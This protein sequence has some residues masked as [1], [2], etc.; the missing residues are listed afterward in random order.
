MPGTPVPTLVIGLGGSGSWTV[1][2]LKQALMDTYDN[3]I[4][5]N[6]ALV[7]L[8]T[9]TK[10]TVR[11][12][13]IEYPR[14]PGEGIGGVQLE[15]GEYA[16]LGGDVYKF[17]QEVRDT[18]QYRHI[19]SWFNA[20]WKLDT[21]PRSQFNLDEGAGMW[22]QFGRMALFY[23]L[24]NPNTSKTKSRIEDSLKR[25]GDTVSGDGSVSVMIVGSMTGGTGAGLFLD[26]AHI[27]KQIAAVNGIKVVIRGF[28]YLPQ[29]FNRDLDAANLERARQRS[30]AAM[31]E[32]ERFLLHDDAK[33]G[34]P[35]HY[36][37]ETA[38]A[39]AR[40]YR[41]EV[42]SKLYDFVYLVDGDG[43]GRKMNNRRLAEAAAPMVADAILAFMDTYFGRYQNQYI[44]NIQAAVQNQQLLRGRQAYVGSLG[45]YSIVL[46]I[47]NIIEGWSYRL[48]LETMSAVVAPG[49]TAQQRG[50]ILDLSATAN[51]E[52]KDTTPQR[53][54][55][56]LLTRDAGIKD[57]TDP[58]GRREFRPYPLWRYVNDFAKELTYSRQN[59]KEKLMARNIEDWLRML[60][61]PRADADDF[62]ARILD[63][64]DAI[65]SETAQERVKT[66]KD[67]KANPGSDHRRVINEAEDF[68]F[69]Q[70]GRNE[71]GGRREGGE[72]GQALER[73][74]KAQVDRF[75]RGMAAYIANTLNGSTKDDAKASK[76]GKLGW[77]IKVFEEIK[78][79]FDQAQSLIANVR[80]DQTSFSNQEST[81]SESMEEMAQS[82]RE[83]AVGRAGPAHR[84]QVD[85][86][87]LVQ[88][89]VDYHRKALLQDYVRMAI[90]GIIDVIEQEIETQFNN[91]K[92]ALATHND[93][94]YNSLLR[95]RNR[96]DNERRTANQVRS[97][98]II[99]DQQWEDK[100]YDEYVRGAGKADVLMLTAWTWN[101]EVKEDDNGDATILMGVSLNSQDSAEKLTNDMRGNWTT[102]NQDVLLKYARRIFRNAVQNESI[103]EFLMNSSNINDPDDDRAEKRRGF[104]SNPTALGDFLKSVC[105][106]QLNID[107][108][109]GI[110]YTNVLLAK[111]DPN[112]SV[113]DTASKMRPNQFLQDA[114]DQL[115]QQEG[116]AAAG[117]GGNAAGANHQVLEC[118]DP[119]RLTIVSGAEVVPVSAVSAYRTN[120]SDYMK[121]PKDARAVQH[122][123]TPEQVAVDYEESLAR[124]PGQSRRVLSTSMI[125][126]LQDEERLELFFYYVAYKRI[127]RF[128]IEVDGSTKFF[129]GLEVRKKDIGAYSE[130]TEY[131]YL[132]EPEIDPYFLEAART[133]ILR[134]KD[135]R[136]Y[137][138]A[139]TYDN[140]LPSKRNL[141]QYMYDFR[142]LETQQRI[143]HNNLALD[144]R[145]L[146]E[147]YS[148][149]PYDTELRG[150]LEAFMPEIAE[151]EDAE[152]GEIY[153]DFDWDSFTPDEKRAFD[154][155]AEM[156]VQHDVL[157]EL[158]YDLQ[159][160]LPTRKANLE[161]AQQ[162]RSTNLGHEDVK[163]AE[164]E[165]DF[166][167]LAV[168]AL[169][170]QVQALRKKVR[171]QYRNRTGQRDLGG[172][173]E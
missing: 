159:N 140:D 124:L 35:M 132:S 117:A 46:P 50:T 14:R 80:S 78:R 45:A 133:F 171:T 150:W 168:L 156:V 173:N 100:R 112:I 126:V 39:T 98:W 89:Y 38:S 62:T 105:G 64:T 143:E 75:R 31:R 26:V 49:E 58:T 28:L 23:D 131:I 85:F 51:V 76:Q 135:I 40:I 111:I 68:I 13:A 122:I 5:S 155:I 34:Y 137:R 169:D 103:V 74:A 22:R 94:L 123:F 84:A 30:Y 92:Q 127:R 72:Y 104:V 147:G 144:V 167:S 148:D 151:F 70:L 121:L 125:D 21:L 7:A 153:E 163:R 71:E 128:S 18:E 66:S 37:E 47:Q 109:D 41:S 1:V 10:P 138:S 91:W 48:A 172:I 69:L 142:H 3:E 44:A 19:R 154:E 106:P 82:V 73:L 53:E 114:L 164:A 90:L 67:R 115:A 52:R 145:K 102:L 165:Y 116:G 60:Q 141:V 95:G 17:V 9:L 170:K 79:S 87:A 56:Q 152:T 161:E 77:L 25:I 24:L 129:W 130:E 136:S 12:G 6:V 81:L 99:N 20:K 139:G 134:Q 61:P 108:A 54:A 110:T 33:F 119:F 55:E 11:V 15:P 96:I 4:P 29:T 83:K 118:S 93:S 162:K 63:D 101:V 157:D 166:F 43:T 107:R 120:K 158:R 146:R 97:R 149:H 86:L 32:L 42:T 57:P 160:F 2:H 16:H 113:D 88:E 59:A 36:V 27:V 65:I 8:D